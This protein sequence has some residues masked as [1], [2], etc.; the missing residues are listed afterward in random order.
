MF[1]F[2]LLTGFFI[3]C[4]CFSR[5]VISEPIVEHRLMPYPQQLKLEPHSPSLVLDNVKVDVSHQD[6]MLMAALD[7]FFAQLYHQT[8][9][10]I[11]QDGSATTTL[12][13]QLNERPLA[14]MPQLHDDE[15]YQLTI[16]AEGIEL[17]AENYT[18]ALHG[19]QTLLQL[20]K[21]NDSKVQLPA[22]SIR[23]QPRFA[24]RGLLLDPARHFLPV[25]TI[26]RQ[27]DGMAA[28]KLNVLHWHLTDDQGW[29]MES[30]RFP[31]L[32]QVGGKD[33]YYTQQEIRDIVDY[34][35]ERGIRVVPEIDLPGHT[36]AL[37]AAYPQLMAMPGPD[38]P[39]I[40]WG[41]HPAVLDPTKD[42]VYDFIEQLLIEVTELFPDHYIHIG[43]DEVLPD[44]WHENER[45]QQFMQQ[46]QLDDHVALQNYFNQR[47][48]AIM[49]TLDRHMIGWDEVLTPE[50]PDSVLVQSWRGMDSMA[51]AAE[52]G[53]GA[54]LS[55]GFYLDQ[56]QTAGYHYRIDPL[57]TPSAVIPDDQK[58]WSSW[59]LSAERKRGAPIQAELYLLY[60]SDHTIQGYIDFSGRSRIKVSQL[61]LEANRLRFQVDSWMGPVQAELLLDQELTGQL[62]VGNAPY[63][64]TGQQQAHY[65]QD[66]AL[67]AGMTRP[68]LSAEA[69]R[70][71]LGGEI[72]LWGEM[73]TKDVIDRRLWPQAAVVAERLWSDSTINDEDF[74]YQRLEHI[75]HWLASSVGLLHTTQQQNGFSSLISEQGLSALQQFVIALEPAHYYHR[76][77]EKSVREHYHNQAPLN[78][79]V[80]FLPA[81]Q[82]QFRRLHQLATTW[83]ESPEHTDI[84]PLKQHLI[85]W[86]QAPEQLQPWLHQTKAA[87]ELVPLLSKVSELAA[88]G[89][90]LLDTNQP[91]T[92]QERKHLRTRVKETQGIHAEMV[93]ALERLISQLLQARPVSTVWVPEG[94]TSGIEGPAMGPDGYLYVV[95][96]QQE[97]TIGRVSP[98]GHTELYLTLPEGSIGNGIQLTSEHH[99]MI[100]DYTGNAILRYHPDTTILEVFAHNP[101]MHQPNDLTISKSGV[102]FASDPDWSQSKGQ[103]WRIDTDGSSH[104]L[105]AAIGTSNGIEILPDQQWLWVNE[106]VQRRI[107]RYPIQPGYA[108]GERQFVA[109]FSSA[110]LDGMRSNQ[111]GQIAVTR[112]GNGTVLLLN[113][114]GQLLTEIPLQNQA[115]TN[116]AFGPGYLLV[117]MQDCGCIERV[118][119]PPGQF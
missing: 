4:L 88:I 103:L 71:I 63:A 58:A 6:D 81:E 100:A 31:R 78:R 10:R 83:L 8:G 77:H 66:K 50:L 46:H 91:L 5:V 115:P 18:G 92:L 76:L 95:N 28:M 93:I 44:H 87:Q 113:K 116:L 104:L 36:T 98:E 40:H 24:W 102:I 7:R 47:L 42:E 29:R 97:G 41:V 20:A 39:E 1:R 79:L 3:S 43:G 82:F 117:T 106:S 109:A 14:Y 86:Q 75:E 118:E 51:Q 52:Q 22:V 49:S 37:G 30:K 111:H 101:A 68:A 26:K 2:V 16:S 96:Y 9:V 105:E 73:V 69:Q 74:M 53:H 114:Q 65:Q 32:H 108:L 38:E 11:E 34:A 33:G 70:N 25:R 84:S 55:T 80:D 15:S 119:L 19:L 60:L 94:F 67:P 99:M 110:G 61:E 90:R 45:I 64:V 56:P 27:I 62:V 48:L 54:I 17:T 107:W 89:L 13:V 112:Y 12:H 23:D 57:P 72:A 59:T 35:R 21:H 85:A